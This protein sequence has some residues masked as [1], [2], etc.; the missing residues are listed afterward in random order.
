MVVDFN[1]W[2]HIAGVDNGTTASLYL[3]GNLIGAESSGLGILS[4]DLFIGTRDGT[5]EFLSGL[6]DE[7]G[8]YDRALS[9]TEIQAI[10]DAG[11]AAK[12]KT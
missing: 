5:Q 11:S 7:V 9:Q 3:N 8:L 1:V 12:C 2:S 4:G 10:F 6:I